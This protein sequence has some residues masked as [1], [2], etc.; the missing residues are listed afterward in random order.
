MSLTEGTISYDT[1]EGI[2]RVSAVPEDATQ[3]DIY[4]NEY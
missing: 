1:E 3:T 2:T 4:G